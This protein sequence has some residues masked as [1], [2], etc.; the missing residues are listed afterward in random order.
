[1]RF[2]PVFGDIERGQIRERAFQTVTCLNEHLPV[3][4]EDEEHN[5]VALSFLSNTPRLGDALR[6]IRNLRVTLHFGKDRDHNLVGSFAF[7]L[8]KLFVETERGVFCNHSGI[9][10]EVSRWFRRND[11][12]RLRM[13]R[14]KRRETERDSF[15]ARIGCRSF[16][17]DRQS[18]YGVALTAGEA[19]GAG[20][21]KL[22]FTV[23]AFSAPGWAAKNGRGNLVM[24]LRAAEKN[25]Q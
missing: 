12:R 19:A 21:P 17:Q 15:H 18:R 3:L 20:E 10:V 6:V 8:G 23:G 16:M 7:E 2:D 1:M 4:R 25:R 5:A 9:I 14:D 13:D 22:K 11:F 24:I